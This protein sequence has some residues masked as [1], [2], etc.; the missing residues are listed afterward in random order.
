MVAA[1]TLIGETS[2]RVTAI[3]S[4]KNKLGFGDSQSTRSAVQVHLF[5]TAVFSNG[6]FTVLLRKSL[7][8]PSLRLNRS[9]PLRVNVPA[10]FIQLFT[11]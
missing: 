6:E 3:F 7:P 11:R 1:E 2:E 9:M 8:L 10:I 4:I 5:S